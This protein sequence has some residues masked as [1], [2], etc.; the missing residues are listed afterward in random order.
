VSMG[1]YAAFALLRAAP[2]RVRGLVLADTR[3]EADNETARRSRDSM[4]ATSAS[5]GAAAVFERMLPGLL[6]ATTRRSRPDVVERVRQIAT[7]QPADAIRDAIVRMKRRPDSVPLLPGILFPVQVVVGEEDEIT[8]VE[9][10]RYMHG[11][12]AGA[13]LAIIGHAGHLSNLERPDE[14]NMILDRFL[15]T[16]F[17][18]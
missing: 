6:G 11:Q 14:F 12:I 8:G 17:E 7:G 18:P 4:L 5:G 2:A 13:E 9:I 1:G 15:A 3:P 10:A 16:A